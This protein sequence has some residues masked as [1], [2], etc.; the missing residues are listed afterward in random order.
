MQKGYQFLPGS[1]PR[2]PPCGRGASHPLI[3]SDKGSL[4][5][6]YIEPEQVWLLTE[7]G[8]SLISHLFFGKR[9]LVAI[10]LVIKGYAPFKIERFERIDNLLFYLFGGTVEEV[11]EAGL[12]E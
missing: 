6:S 11:K 7:K 12:I 9:Y 4:S 5:I 2:A 1:H 8:H 3:F 10:C